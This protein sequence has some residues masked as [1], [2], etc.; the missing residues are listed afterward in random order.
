MARY[1]GRF[2][3]E[4]TR[5]PSW[6]YADPGWY[7][8]TICT[9]SGYPFF[10]EIVG[11][12]MHLSPIGEIVAKEWQRTPGIRRNVALDEWCIMPNHLHGILIITTSP[13][14]TVETPRRGV[15]TKAVVPSPSTLQ[16]GS[17]GAII[18]QLKSVCTKRIRR[19]GYTTFAWQARFYDHIIRSQAS[20]MYIRQYIVDNAA[21]WTEDSQHSGDSGLRLPD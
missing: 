6:N 11:H 3:V 10:G 21:R 19:A 12:R 9:Q 2:R 13:E 4:S 5:L 18:G 14:R 8:V 16:P 20:L 1:K 7:F 15:S 17:L